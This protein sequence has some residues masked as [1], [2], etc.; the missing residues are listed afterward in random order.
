MSASSETA[1]VSS[2][3]VLRS[4]ESE[5]SDQSSGTRPAR[6]QTRWARLT[7]SLA[8]VSQLI[9]PCLENGDYRLTC[10]MD[11]LASGT[12]SV[13]EGAFD[14]VGTGG[15]VKL[16]VSPGKLSV[17]VDI[18][19]VSAGKLKETELPGKETSEIESIVKEDNVGRFPV[20]SDVTLGDRFG[21][22]SESNADNVVKPPAENEVTSRSILEK[23]FVNPFARS[24][25]GIPPG[26]IKL[27][28]V[29]LGA[30]RLGGSTSEGKEKLPVDSVGI[31][32]PMPDVPSDESPVGPDMPDV[33]TATE[34]ASGR[35]SE[36][37][38]VPVVNTVTV[39]GGG[40]YVT[41]TEPSQTVQ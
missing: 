13:I 41:V 12:L 3:M 36:T 33:G 14:S 7:T 11:T 34:V 23:L 35:K 39:N 20:S 10:V 29:R 27:G 6:S 16:A 19:V 18:D 32:E 1:S 26:V 38:K 15:R 30:V 17:G 4:S 21:K 5:S 2:A 22:D 31:P 37:L 28:V 40:T 24:L 8:I 9:E 25:V